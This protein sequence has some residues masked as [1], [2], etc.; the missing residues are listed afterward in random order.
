LTAEL[1]LRFRIDLDQ[2]KPRLQAT[3][4][5]GKLGRH[6]FAGTAPRR[7]KINQQRN[8]V[9]LEMP[10]KIAAVQFQRMPFEK[11]LVALPASGMLC[12]SG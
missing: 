5:S 7:P 11:G 10:G 3:G 8:L 9:A 12:Q 2:S 6:H 4:G 1:G